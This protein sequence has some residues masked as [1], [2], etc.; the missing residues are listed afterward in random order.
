[1]ALSAFDDKLRQPRNADLALVMKDSFD[2]WNELKKL[3][4]S[5]FNP[6]CFEWGFTSKT[7]QLPCGLTTGQ[8][9]FRAIS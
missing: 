2:L 1:M 7:G 9:N 3:I 8:A 6:L 4:A 5:R